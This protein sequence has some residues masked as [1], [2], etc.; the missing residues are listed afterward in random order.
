MLVKMSCCT[1]NF[2][3][4]EKDFKFLSFDF[5]SNLELLKSELLTDSFKKAVGQVVCQAYENSPFFYTQSEFDNEDIS[6]ENEKKIINDNIR[7]YYIIFE[8]FISF[9]WLIKDNCCSINS[10]HTSIPD[11]RNV[12][13]KNN[14]TVY[15]TSQGIINEKIY[16][17]HNDLT[18]VINYYLKSRDFFYYKHIRVQKPDE[19]IPKAI[20]PRF[21]GEFDYKKIN[22]IERAFHFLTLARTCSHLSLKIS[23]YMC[24]YEALFYGNS[25]GE[26][27]HQIAERVAL[28]AASA[29]F[30]RVGI[31]KQ[32]KD[33]YNIRSLYFHGK[34]F[35]K[36][37]GDLSKISFCLDNLTR[38]ILLKIV[39][40][41]SA[42]FLQDDD[43]LEKSFQDL[44]FEDERKPQ[45]RTF[46]SGISY[47][48]F[49]N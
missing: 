23:F 11:K 5:T 28:Y 46:E 36:F 32:I 29:R 24:I 17:S 19:I 31:Y 12:I 7:V 16:F 1:N 35:K 26:I 38:D 20:E 6:L 34:S 15:S 47:L 45:G 41:D 21:V 13:V 37:K 22:R 2:L 43:L 18:K 30:I 10:F 39:L 8:T 14:S 42:I 33:A 25:Q 4:L 49:N 44:L 3:P 27:S 48:R 40:K 9:L